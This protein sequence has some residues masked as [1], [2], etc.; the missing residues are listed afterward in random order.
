MTTHAEVESQ[1]LQLA[2]LHTTLGA[3][4]DRRDQTGIHERVTGGKGESRPAPANLTVVEARQAIDLFAWQHA[5]QLID[6]GT[7]PERWPT[8]KTTQQ[9]VGIAQRLGHWTATANTVEADEFRGEL[10]K[11]IADAE[12][13]LSPEPAQWR[14]IDVPCFVD[15]CPGE[16]RVQLPR[17]NDHDG[18]NDA[19]RAR[20]FKDSMP[21]AVCW[22]PTSD[23]RQKIRRDHVILASLAVRD[24]A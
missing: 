24:V 22:V 17:D 10:A 23:G 12:V 13:A 5:K 19:E 3:E 1:L 9:L 8:Q 21:E 6:A 14:R 7:W 2:A 18:R 4:L 15:D 20:A 11:L 16:Y